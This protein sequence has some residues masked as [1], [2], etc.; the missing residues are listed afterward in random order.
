MIQQTD[1]DNLLLPNGSE[2]RKRPCVVR[3]SMKLL[4]DK[5]RMSLQ[6]LFLPTEGALPLIF[7]DKTL[8]T[9]CSY[10]LSGF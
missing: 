10:H 2:D 1:F 7:L 6:T 8:N 3:V 4:Q 5:L 9:I